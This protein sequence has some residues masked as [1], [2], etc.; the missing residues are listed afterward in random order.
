[1]EQDGEQDTRRGNSRAGLGITHWDGE[2]SS[3]MEMAHGYREK[4]TRTQSRAW[5][6]NQCMGTG[7]RAGEEEEDQE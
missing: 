2:Q 4:D 5:G 7:N 3:G 1:M 6:G